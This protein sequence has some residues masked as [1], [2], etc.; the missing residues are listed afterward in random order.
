MVFTAL[1][2]EVIDKVINIKYKISFKIR[3]R[4]FSPGFH[5]GKIF[6]TLLQFPFAIFQMRELLGNAGLE[7]LIIYFL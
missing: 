5:V 3:V 2:I 1:I 7:F 6:S 4:G